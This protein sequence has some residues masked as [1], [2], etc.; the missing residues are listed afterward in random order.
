MPAHPTIREV[1]RAFRIC[2]TLLTETH[3]ADDRNFAINTIINSVIFMHDSLQ[4]AAAEAA[5]MV[6]EAN[7]REREL[8]E[9]YARRK[10][11][12]ARLNRNVK[13]KRAAQVAP[14]QGMVNKTGLLSSS[15]TI[16]LL[17]SI[18]RMGR[19]IGRVEK[20]KPSEMTVGKHFTI[21]RH[22]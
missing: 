2:E 4:E 13:A 7:N 16:H 9:S 10:Q 5:E 22:V 17:E 3:T 20:K 18:P 19:L 14:R 8:A 15:L 21:F 6:R 12:I 1:S 11:H